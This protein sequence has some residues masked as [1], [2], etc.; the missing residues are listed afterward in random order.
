MIKKILSGFSTKDWILLGLVVLTWGANASA[1]KV[2][3]NEIEPSTLAFIRS[4]LTAIL[5][6]P[7]IKKISWGDFKNVALVSFVFFAIHYSVM[8][9]SIDA[10]NS[11]SFVVLVMLAMP[12]TIILSSIFLNEKIGKWTWF[13]IV[14]C[15]VGLMIAFG[16]PDIAQY[17]MGAL[18]TLLTAILWAIG[19]LLMKRTKHIPLM[20]F[21]FY[22]FGLA[23]PFLFVFA[24]AMNG[25]AMFDFTSVNPFNLSVSVFYQV[26][27]MGVMASVWGY[28][29][30]NHRA[31][32]VTPFL[33]LQVPV[34]AMFGYIL[35]GE[36]IT[37]ELIASA[38]V[39]L[40]GVGVI[41]YR[42]LNS[43]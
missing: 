42:R 20:T 6:A 28:L 5:F 39:I 43:A 14:V 9:M 30:G 8:Y 19:S 11:N 16:I 25:N 33:L 10:I 23:A 15:F 41:H 21:T 1:V 36:A 4:S 29:I 18:F 12:F 2:G 24:Y 22:A 38:I 35:L 31:D 13:G 32:H 27:V 37:I 3:T 40:A 17:P 7:F 34:A 26:V